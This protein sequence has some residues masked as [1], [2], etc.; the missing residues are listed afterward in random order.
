M[1]LKRLPVQIHTGEAHLLVFC[2]IASAHRIVSTLADIDKSTE[3]HTLKFQIY[4]C[5]ECGTFVLSTGDDFEL[6]LSTQ[7]LARVAQLSATNEAPHEAE[8]SIIRPILQKTSARLASLDA[9]IPRLKAHLAQLEEQRAVI[10]RYHA[11]NLSI[12]SPLRRMPPEILGEIFSWTIRPDVCSTDKSP[13]VLTH[14]CGDWRTVALS[15]SSLWSLIY[16]DFSVKEKYPL[17]MVNTQVERARSL[18][19][20]F[21]GS[22]NCDSASQIAV[23][24]LLASHSGRWEDLSIQLTSHLVPHMKATHYDL[25]ALRRVWVQWD[26]STSRS[27]PPELDSIDFFQSAISLVEIA[28][29]SHVRFVPTRFPV[30]HQLTRYDLAAPWQTH[31]GLLKSLPNLQDVH[32]RRFFDDGEDWPAPEDPID[33]LHLRR[34]YVTDPTTLNYLRAPGLE[35]LVTQSVAIHTAETRGSLERFLVRSCCSPRR[36]C[37][38]GLLDVHMAAILQKYPS[39]TE[40]TVT[41]EFEEDESTQRDI[42]STFLALFTISDSTPSAMALPHITK[43]GF[44][45][46]NARAVLCPLF[47]NMVESRRSIEGCALSNAELLLLD[48]EAP[49]DSQSMAR[50]ETL[51]KAGLEVSFWFGRRAQKSADRW[52]H[53]AQWTRIR[54]RFL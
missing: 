12:L 34:L 24:D 25:T 17:E 21:F 46:E 1:I 6:N 7:T 13:W 30:V 29:I 42:F 18:K 22:Q 14:V 36:L 8:L 15:K 35:E 39:I 5:S 28:V 26:D 19:I 4:G 27:Q 44:A 37:I 48:C 9:E 50:I 38:Q 2:A 10:S 41:D 45:C 54:E 32:I 3:I 52:F 53:T 11:Q 31:C 40:I 16:I 49:P 47:L 33:M 23:F 51:R 43:V 20:H